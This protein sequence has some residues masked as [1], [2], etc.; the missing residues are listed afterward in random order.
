MG[1]LSSS[2]NTE[3]Y[4]LIR[5]QAKCEVWSG[6][7][8]AE[9]TCL[10]LSTPCA[11]GALL[12]WRLQ[13]GATLNS[14]SPALS[15]DQMEWHCTWSPYHP[16]HPPSLLLLQPTW[17]SCPR[18]QGGSDSGWEPAL[19]GLRSSRTYYF[20]QLVFIKKHSVLTFLLLSLICILRIF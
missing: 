7:W 2:R 15:V 3:V 5:V 18:G 4:K 19:S 1:F 16:P 13:P 9:R 17:H 12:G 20:T 11:S 8:S 10:F 6:L 14:S